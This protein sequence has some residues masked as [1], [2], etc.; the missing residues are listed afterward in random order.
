[1]AQCLLNELI[2]ASTINKDIKTIIAVIGGKNVKA[3][4]KIHKKNG[5]NIVGTLKK[6]GFKKNQWLDSIYMQKILNE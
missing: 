5:F 2:K 4:I 3:S 1:M 6:V